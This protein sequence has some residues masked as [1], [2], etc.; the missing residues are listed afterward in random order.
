MRGGTSTKIFLGFMGI[1]FVLGILALLMPGSAPPHDIFAAF[2]IMCVFFLLHQILGFKRVVPL[3]LGI[4][5]IPHL[6][7]LYW[8]FPIYEGGGLGTL[9]GAPQLGY[10]YDWFV[11]SFAMFCYTLAFAS[12]SYRYLMKGLKSSFVFFVFI[13]FFMSG[14]GALNESMEYVGFEIFGYGEGF[15]EFGDGDSSPETGPW[16]NASMDMVSNFIGICLGLWVFL[17]FKK[18]SQK[19]L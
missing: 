3:L 13:L 8:I 15:L 18:G 7:G 14:V 10:H 5:F 16:Q 6:L 9:Y 12:V 4:G 1:Y 19:F 2:F 17:F 11:H